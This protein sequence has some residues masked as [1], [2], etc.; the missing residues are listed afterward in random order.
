MACRRMADL[1]DAS[2]VSPIKVGPARE[3]YYLYAVHDW[4]RQGTE[5]FLGHPRCQGQTSGEE[6]RR[7]EA[8]ILMGDWCGARSRRHG[9]E[10]TDASE[11]ANRGWSVPSGTQRKKCQKLCMGE[12]LPL[13]RYYEGPGGCLS[14]TIIVSHTLEEEMD[15]GE[16]SDPAGAGPGSGLPDGVIR[17]VGTQ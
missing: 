6:A 7:H 9:N 17:G 15:H 2:A 3:P 14:G 12:V 5:G 4:T 13:D 11:I 8:L 10:N 1:C 16:P